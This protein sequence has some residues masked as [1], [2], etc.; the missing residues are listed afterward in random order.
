MDT[1]VEKA[2]IFECNFIF[3]ANLQTNLHTVVHFGSGAWL[4]EL[5]LSHVARNLYSASF[6]Y[7]AHI[8]AV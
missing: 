8:F 6:A 5:D 3:E 7:F 2:S 1:V 4:V